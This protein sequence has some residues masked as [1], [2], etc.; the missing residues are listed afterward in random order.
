MEETSRRA[1]YAEATRDAL[2]EAGM[3]VFAEKGYGAASTEEIVKRARVTRGALY[4]H[5]AG[6]AELFRAV[7]EKLEEIGLER[8][9]TTALSSSDPWEVITRGCDAFLDFSLEPKIQRI[10]LL[11]AP[12]VL[13]WE[14]FREIDE[15]Y[16]LG[17]TEQV[18]KAAMDAGVIVRQPV[19]PFAQMLLGALH[20]AVHYIVDS[21][22][23]KKARKE[24]GQVLL[25]LLEGLKA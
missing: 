8:I 18:L 3:D 9:A 14:V 21:D 20:N 19:E 23:P 10:L 5:F 16:S 15:R 13:G 17:T 6:K 25:R 4:H 2:I 22:D 24:A 11:D 1:E 7:V 12:S